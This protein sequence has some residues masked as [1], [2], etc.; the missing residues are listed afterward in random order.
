MASEPL[1]HTVRRR[2]P[3]SSIAAA[4]EAKER[5]K[6]SAGYPG[7][8]PAIRQRETLT[9]YQGVGGQEHLTASQATGSQDAASVETDPPSADFR[10]IRVIYREPHGARALGIA[11]WVAGRSL[12]AAKNSSPDLR[13]ILA[14]IG[15]SG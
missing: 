4:F 1:P 13:S 12:L 7:V 5:L 14:F 11:L 2:L 6:A 8:T 15:N 9:Q 10:G 3:I